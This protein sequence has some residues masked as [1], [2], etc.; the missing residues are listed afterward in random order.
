MAMM[1]QKLNGRKDGRS[2]QPL[3]FIGDHAMSIMA[4]AMLAF[5]LFIAW[6]LGG[7]DTITEED[8]LDHFEN[9]ERLRRRNFRRW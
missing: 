4:S 8:R 6:L 1:Q 7:G 2:M 3:E 9:Q 5:I